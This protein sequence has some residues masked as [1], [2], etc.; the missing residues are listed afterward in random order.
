MSRN[1]QGSIF[2]DQFCLTRPL[3]GG[4]KGIA[5]VLGF[6]GDDAQLRSLKSSQSSSLCSVAGNV[7]NLPPRTTPVD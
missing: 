1:Q 6:R 3:K 2:R 7:T 5:Y 4:Y